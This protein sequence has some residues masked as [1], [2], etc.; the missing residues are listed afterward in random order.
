MSHVIGH[1]ANRPDKNQTGFV[2]KNNVNGQSICHS[3]HGY[4]VHIEGTQRNRQ[5]SWSEEDQ[6]RNTKAK[7]ITI[8]V[9]SIHSYRRS[10]TSIW[11]NK[12]KRKGERKTKSSHHNCLIAASTSG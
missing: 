9:S 8:N 1:P 10:Y 11:R 2:F 12:R 3:Y 7:K 4:R 5:K 6:L